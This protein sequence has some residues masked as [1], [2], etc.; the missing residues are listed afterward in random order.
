M[1]IVPL[2][3]SPNFIRKLGKRFTNY[4][5]FQDCFPNEIVLFLMVIPIRLVIKETT[6]RKLNWNIQHFYNWLIFLSRFFSCSSR[7]SSR[8]KARAVL[9]QGADPSELKIFGEHSHP[10]DYTL[11]KKA[12][13]WNLIKQFSVTLPGK[14][15]QVY[16]SVVS[17][18]VFA[19]FT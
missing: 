9:E 16:S 8:C 6:K 19:E 17:L 15:A 2:I 3:L 14:P 7:R 1:T 13:I 11:E 5:V 18:W 12:E 10:P 4:I